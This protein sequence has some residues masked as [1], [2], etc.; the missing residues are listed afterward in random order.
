[1]NQMRDIS[2][3]QVGT[4]PGYSLALQLVVTEAVANFLLDGKTRNVVLNIKDGAVKCV[5]VEEIVPV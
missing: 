2:S 1:M 5:R 4:A 3:H